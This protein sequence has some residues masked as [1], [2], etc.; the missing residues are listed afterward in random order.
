MSHLKAGDTVHFLAATSLLSGLDL[1]SSMKPI[2]CRRGTVLEVTAEILEANVDK[3]GRSIFDLI[4]SPDEQIAA[5]GRVIVGRGKW[6]SGLATW[7]P[8]TVEERQAH[9]AALKAASAISDP[10]ARRDEMTRIRRVF[11]ELKSSFSI[12]EYAGDAPDGMRP[13]LGLVP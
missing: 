4:D 9:E 6:P 3:N 11:G 10:V 7:E 1:A 2:E 13:Q 12:A 8:N 5:R